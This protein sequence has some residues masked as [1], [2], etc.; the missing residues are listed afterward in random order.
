MPFK[1]VSD[2][3][4]QAM[5]NIGWKDVE[6]VLVKFGSNGEHLEASPE[7]DLKEIRKEL[8]IK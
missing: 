8:G 2:L 4:K 6:G 7:D 1:N 5:I 3:Q